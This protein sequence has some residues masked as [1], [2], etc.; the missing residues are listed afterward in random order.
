MRPGE[1][2]AYDTYSTA[3]NQ[4]TF[5][6]LYCRIKGV[7]C[8]YHRSMCNKLYICIVCI[9]LQ[10]HVQ[11]FILTDLT[12]G[13][14]KATVH[15]YMCTKI[16]LYFFFVNLDFI[17][18]YNLHCCLCSLSCMTGCM[19]EEMESE[20]TRSCHVSFSCFNM[21][22]G[23]FLGDAGIPWFHNTAQMGKRYKGIY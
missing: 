10:L 22:F 18:Q 5:W 13:K 17:T 11:L 9:L 16:L 23:M 14:F 4:K 2:S 21:F 20:S 7:V 15:G 19:I 6:L 1:T 8:E 12:E 3:L